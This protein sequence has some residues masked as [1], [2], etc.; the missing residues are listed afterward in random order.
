MKTSVVKKARSAP[1]KENSSQAW[2]EA[3]E[4]R[5]SDDQPIKPLEPLDNTQREIPKV[6]TA[7]AP[8]G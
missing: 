5:T 3:R 4:I 6:G 7:D 2:P 8:G 1:G